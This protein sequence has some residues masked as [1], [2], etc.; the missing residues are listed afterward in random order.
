MKCFSTRMKV[1][2]LLGLVI[3]F[4]ILLVFSVSCA[5]DIR[6]RA[7]AFDGRID[8]TAQTSLTSGRPA[9]D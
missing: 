9:R 7:T 4:L 3:V 5:I 6:G 8:D 2:L 1:G